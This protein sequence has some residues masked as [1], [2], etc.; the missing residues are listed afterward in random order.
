MAITITLNGIEVSGHPGMTILDLARESGVE[1]PT[2][3]HDPHLKPYGACRVC[4]VEDERNGALLASCVAPIAPGMVIN[5]RSPKVIESRKT[6]VKLML[7]SH[8]DSCMVCDKGNRCRLR[9]IAADLGIG[10]VDFQRIPHPSPLIDVNPFIERD[11]SKCILCAKCIRADHELVVEGAIDYLNRGFP[12]KPATVGDLPLEVSECTFCGTC[13]A[14]CPTAALSEKEKP[15]HG[16]T[17]RVVPTVCGF[18]GCGCSIDM[19]VSGNKIVR[20]RPSDVPRSPNGVTLC[21]RGSYGYDYVQSPDR[22][23]Q[24]LVKVDGE[25]RPVS[26]D[27]AVRTVADR[28]GRVK[29]AHG[30]DTLAVLGCAKCTNEEN[31][32]L[33]WFARNVLETNNIDNGGRLYNAAARIGLMET[34]GVGA[35]SNPIDDIEKSQAILVVGADPEVSAPIV[36]YAVKRAVKFNGAKLLVINP[37]RTKLASFARMWLRP[38]SGTDGALVNGLIRAIIDEGL[39]NPDFASKT[40]QDVESFR[41]S[42]EGFGP[43]VVEDAAGVPADDLGAAARLIGESDSLSIIFGTGVTQQAGGSEVVASLANLSLITGNLGREGAGIYSIQVENNAQGA[44]DMGCIPDFLPGYRKL[45]RPGLTA[46]EMIGGAAEGKIKA[47][48]IVGENPAVSFPNPDATRQALSNLEFLVVQDM[49]L[50]DTA[51]LADVVLPA[52]SFAEK[53]GTFTSFER[54][55]QR[56]QKAIEPVGESLPD[57]QIIERLSNAMGKPMPYDS[58]RSIMEEISKAVPGYE[59]IDYDALVPGGVHWPRNGNRFG[60]PRLFEEGFPEGAGR[61]AGVGYEPP[62]E[63]PANG[64]RFELLAARVLYKFGSGSRSSKS[65]RLSR[66]VP[67]PLL[68]VN[69]TDADELGIGSGDRVRVTSPAGEVIARADVSSAVLPGT[70]MLPMSY[71]GSPTSALFDVRLDPRT[72]SP[73]AKSCRVKVERLE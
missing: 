68:Q 12:S 15:Y 34:L 55:V 53:D 36:S 14:V 49:F 50:T 18:C 65:A 57:W 28:L 44:S 62:A 25:F 54:R 71:L 24:P 6:I 39:W 17:R 10:L 1:I 13:V 69:R 42:L 40:G 20:V 48:Y 4:L 21:V 5:T 23:A 56:V 51:G 26:W 61:L 29:S 66:M 32:V 70:V 67:D 35:G 41:A 52:C 2:L 3:C 33:Q 9:Q 8:P 16:S 63:A 22:L 47:M 11:L 7:A 43:E 19:E 27:E 58:P 46:L 31:Y 72:K 37:W 38:R 73:L 64:Y 45:D 30:S 60:T 59:G